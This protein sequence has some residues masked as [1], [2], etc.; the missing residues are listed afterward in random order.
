VSALA[1]DRVSV[2]VAPVV[3]VGFALVALALRDVSTWAFLVPGAGALAVLTAQPSSR[4]RGDRGTWLTVTALGIAAFAAVRLAMP[5]VAIHMT[6]LGLLATVVAGV[7]EEIVFR[8]GLYGVV[9]RFGPAFAIL[10][11]AV[12]FGVVHAPMYGWAVV[13]IDVGAG[14][15]FGWQRWATGGWTSPAITHVLA[16]LAGA[17]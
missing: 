7:C 13:P 1:V 5:G 15:V 16:N 12:V 14:L 8:R 4:T 3:A 17:I 11:T 9:E 2:R 10:A 6:S